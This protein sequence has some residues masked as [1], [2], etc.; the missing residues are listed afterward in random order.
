MKAMI[1]AAGYGQ[2]MRPL[3]DS[4]PKPLLPVLSRPLIDYILYRMISL[5]IE[6]VGVNTHHLA[7]A[8]V[9]HL[10]REFSEKIDL[11]FSH[12]EVIAGTG[13]GMR[14][15]RAFL[16]GSEAFLVHN[17]DVF[18]TIPLSGAVA[19][20]QHHNPLVTMV[21]VD[22]PPVNTVSISADGSVTGFTLPGD[23]RLSGGR[24]LTFAGIS[25]V[26]PAVLDCIPPGV[27]YDIIELYQELINEQPGCIKGFP[28]LRDYWIDVGTP[29]A[30]LQL[31][32]DIL[33]HKKAAAGQNPPPCQ[34][35]YQGPGTRVDPTAQLRGFVSLGKDCRVENHAVLENCVVWDH[36]VVKAHSMFS[37]GVIHGSRHYPLP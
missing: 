34:G 32:Q 4:C 18:S 20:H 3:S 27:P 31:H 28:C 13:G 9:A 5:G 11:I 19:F 10:G 37:H 1:M 2:R 24:C 29:A 14:G 30:Y 16:T 22:H 15:L 8:L 23:A 33:L 17:S 35:V 26:N 7:D 6:A 21:L 36:S 12:E 25:L